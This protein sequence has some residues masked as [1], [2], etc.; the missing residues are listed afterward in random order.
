MNTP[1]HASDDY[2][3]KIDRI[4]MPFAFGEASRRA[5]P[6][7]LD[8]AEVFDARVDVIHGASP[9]HE[10]MA[11]MGPG[12][13]G[14]MGYGMAVPAVPMDEEIDVMKRRL[15]KYVAE[16]TPE[17]SSRVST[18]VRTAKV[19]DLFDDAKGRYDLV[20]MGTRDRSWFERV[21]E[22]S[23]AKLAL[24]SLDCPILIVPEASE[25]SSE[26]ERQD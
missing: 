23:K 10:Q 9:L 15:D 13:G 6:Y 22:R 19:E 24:D 8:L 25:K 26:E 16:A 14:A 20:V 3:V 2:H 11:A 18:E 12:I 17:G 21:M 5:L 4:L 1:T 7:A